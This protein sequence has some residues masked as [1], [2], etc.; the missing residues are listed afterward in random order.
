ME[1]PGVHWA[2]QVAFDCEGGPANQLGGLRGHPTLNMI[3][4]GDQL[5]EWGDPLG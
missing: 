5:V 1:N 2:S 4:W 3:G